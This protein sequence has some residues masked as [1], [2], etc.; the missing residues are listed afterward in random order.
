MEEFMIKN[1]VS[2][3]GI[4][5]TFIV[6]IISIVAYLAFKLGKKQVPDSYNTDRAQCKIYEDEMNKKMVPFQ[7]LEL[8]HCNGKPLS[9]N[10]IYWKP[11]NKCELSENNKC[12]FFN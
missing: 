5:G 6:L 7:I 3:F 12:K 9:T 2:I 8:T 4:T 1:A 10:C 11:K